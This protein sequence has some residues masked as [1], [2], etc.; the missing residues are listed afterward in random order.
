MV[1]GLARP[2]KSWH[3]EQKWLDEEYP[4]IKQKA[5]KEGA[6][7]HWGDETGARNVNQLKCRKPYEKIFPYQDIKYAA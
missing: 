3:Y 6:V 4:A 2:L 5:K 1:Y 7:I